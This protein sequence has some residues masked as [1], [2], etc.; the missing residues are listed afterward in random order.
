MSTLASHLTPGSQPNPAKRH[1]GALSGRVLLV[2]DCPDLLNLHAHVLKGFGLDVTTAVNGHEACVI[3]S[4][5]L[6]LR[7]SFNVIVTDIAMPVMDGLTAATR[8]RRLGFYGAIIAVTATVN[9]VIEQQCLL[10]GCNAYLPKPLDFVRLQRTLEYCL[11]PDY[12]AAEGV[13]S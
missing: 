12:F 10:A 9:H 4:A 8:M 13:A 3:V 6:A 2:D 11:S 1:A 7:Q 5:T